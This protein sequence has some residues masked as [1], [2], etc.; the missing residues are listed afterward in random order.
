LILHHMADGGD[1]TPME[2][3]FPSEDQ[4]EL[5]RRQGVADR[6]TEEPRFRTLRVRKACL[7]GRFTLDD[8]G[9]HVGDSGCGPSS[10][11]D[12]DGIRRHLC[13]RVADIGG[14]PLAPKLRAERP[15]GAA[16]DRRRR[17]TVARSI[18]RHRRRVGECARP[19]GP[20]HTIRLPNR[21]PD[22]RARYR[23]RPSHQL[24]QLP[25]GLAEGG[26]VNLIRR[27]GDR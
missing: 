11:A 21:R 2:P 24:L 7:I 13:R 18:R 27:A 15:A 4:R 3:N 16:N 20:A 22:R 26:Q 25:H 14:Y 10:R 6:D 1:A 9:L 8:C 5:I 12:D 23:H 19:A 17:G